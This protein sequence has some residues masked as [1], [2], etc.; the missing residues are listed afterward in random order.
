[1]DPF[2]YVYLTALLNKFMIIYLMRSLS[3]VI[4]NGNFGS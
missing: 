3:E 1:M 4:L 2:G